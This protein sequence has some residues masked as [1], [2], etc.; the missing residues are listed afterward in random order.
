MMLL[1]I[2][3]TTK[4]HGTTA[5]RAIQTTAVAMHADGSGTGSSL[6]SWVFTCIK[7]SVNILGFRYS[8]M[9]M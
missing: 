5:W 7:T 8:M 2:E 1:D 9:C 3:H 6:W 4:I